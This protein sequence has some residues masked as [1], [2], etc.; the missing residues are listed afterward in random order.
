MQ[1]RLIQKISELGMDLGKHMNY[2]ICVIT[3]SIITAKQ[4]YQDPKTQECGTQ[5]EVVIKK[6]RK[7]MK[8]KDVIRVL[9]ALRIDKG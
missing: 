8:L 9:K 3:L 5:W 6:C 7:I 1:F 2:K 4:F